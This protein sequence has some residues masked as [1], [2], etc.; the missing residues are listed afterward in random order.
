[1]GA[2]RG[3]AITR[4]DDIIAQV[5]RCRKIVTNLL[6]FARQQEPH[7]EPVELN[8]LV[9]QVLQLRKYDLQT[10]NIRIV[11]HFDPSSPVVI[12]DGDKLQQVVLNL[13]NNAHDAVTEAGRAGTIWV[14]T[15]ADGDRVTLEF[16]DDG[17]GFKDPERAFEPFYTTKEVGKGTGLGLSV[18][19][20]IVREHQGEITAENWL[21][22][23]RVTVTLPM[24][25]R[26]GGRPA[27]VEQREPSTVPAVQP[28]GDPAGPGGLRALVVDDEDA[29]ARMQVAFLSR[30]GISAAA[31]PTGE[32][33]IRYLERHEVDAVISDVRMPGSVDG[34]QLYR[35][36]QRNRPALADRF[37]FA[38]G[39]IVGL[40]L[41]EVF[42]E[43]P[44]RRIQKPFRFDVYR[45]VV[46]E[47]VRRPRDRSLEAARAS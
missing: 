21:K 13:L 7:V 17:P 12:A 14:R 15:K 46:S 35:W 16:L 1:M 22:G 11:R 38:S 25:R 2:D 28:T 20:G 43:I 44:V 40:N 41:D 3:P 18:C 8:A 23:A 30:M 4:C 19:Y 36:V 26:E 31:V 10:K 39:D 29:L 24:G 47:V 27:A 34:V 42:A 9:E 37:V 32:A 6:Q 5:E 45:Q 33:G